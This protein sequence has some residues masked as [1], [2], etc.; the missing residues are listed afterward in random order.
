ML[1]DSADI[2]DLDGGYSSRLSP[3]GGRLLPVVGRLAGHFHTRHLLPFGCIALAN[4]KVLSKLLKSLDRNGS[5]AAVGNER[6][7]VSR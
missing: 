7:K 1:G 4:M 2:R 5:S 6:W 3:T